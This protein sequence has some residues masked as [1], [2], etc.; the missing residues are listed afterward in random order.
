MVIIQKKNTDLTR[1][2]FRK[3]YPRKQWCREKALRN[4]VALQFL[5]IEKKL[6]EISESDEIRSNPEPKIFIFL[7]FQDFRKHNLM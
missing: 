3:K 5:K 1:K 4:F 6:S 7:I 2:R